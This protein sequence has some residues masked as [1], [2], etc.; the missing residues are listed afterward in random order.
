MIHLSTDLRKGEPKLEFVDDA[1]MIPMVLA[2]LL[3]L[4]VLLGTA[5]IIAIQKEE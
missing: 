2:L 3:E 1:D 5:P 4:V